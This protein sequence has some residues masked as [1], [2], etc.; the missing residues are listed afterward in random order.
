MKLYN[1]DKYD[2]INKDE[3]LR[4][5]VGVAKVLRPELFT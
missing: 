1:F 5:Q 4:V 3:Y 2:C